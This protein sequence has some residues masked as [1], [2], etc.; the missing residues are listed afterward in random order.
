M[1]ENIDYIDPIFFIISIGI[2]CLISFIRFNQWTES[3]EPFEMRY[4]PAHYTSYSAFIKFQTAYMLLNLIAYIILISFPG[5]VAVILENIAQSEESTGLLDRLLLLSDGSMELFLLLIFLVLP[6]YNRRVKHIENTIRERLQSKAGIPTKVMDFIVQSLSDPRIF[7]PKRGSIREFLRERRGLK[8]NPEQVLAQEDVMVDQESDPRDVLE[9]LKRLWAKENYL[10]YQIQQ[11]SQ[12]HFEQSLISTHFDKDYQA[13]EVL[14]QALEGK[15]KE[16]EATDQ[17]EGE[18]KDEIENLAS[19]IRSKLREQLKYIYLYISVGLGGFT[20]LSQ[21]NPAVYWQFGLFPRYQREP[22]FDWVLLARTAGILLIG[23]FFISFAA[24]SA[25]S[26]LGAEESNGASNQKE[27]TQIGI[28]QQYREYVQNVVKNV[29]EMVFP[30]EEQ[31]AGSIFGKSLRITVAATIGFF[32]P[33]MF[34][35]FFYDLMSGQQLLTEVG[36]RFFRRPS[37]HLAWYLFGFIVGYF[38]LLITLEIFYPMSGGRFSEWAPILRLFTFDARNGFSHP[39]W[40]LMGGLTGVW[41][42]V[43]IKK[44]LNLPEEPW[45]IMW[46]AIFQAISFSFAALL[47]HGFKNGFNYAKVSYPFVALAV[48]FVIGLI[49]GSVVPWLMRKQYLQN[50]MNSLER[51][52]HKRIN[53]R[54]ETVLQLCDDGKGQIMETEPDCGEKIRCLIMNL[55]PEGVSVRRKYNHVRRKLD[56]KG[57]R[58][59][60]KAKLFFPRLGEVFGTLRQ[61]DEHA[62]YLEFD[63]DSNN[64]HEIHEFYKILVGERMPPETPFQKRRPE[65]AA[66]QTYQRADNRMIEAVS[67][68]GRYSI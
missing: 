53:L 35:F 40:A 5:L 51:R 23:I 54:I 48:S 4:S 62:I 34:I 21:G 64:L 33:V 55:T 42:L 57:L 7:R 2:V 39:Y 26:I 20:E 61:R 56:D 9:Q 1:L 19:V 27:G 68:R 15:I 67:S 29:S 38:V 24:L 59:G 52:R 17:K 50:V 58:D 46:F 6:D 3:S 43:Y 36:S 10:L 63:E 28:V 45:R 44:F 11:D 18:L 8:L 41:A 22:F 25:R 37:V 66:K 47:I 60:A 16:H 49:L 13:V 65:M 30:T 14:L 32:L 12:E 31:G